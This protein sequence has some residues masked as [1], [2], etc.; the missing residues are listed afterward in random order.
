MS[1]AHEGTWAV[2]IERL[3]IELAVGIHAHGALALS[4]L[5]CH[6]HAAH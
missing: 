6:G 1:A 4:T 2:R 5:P 3:P